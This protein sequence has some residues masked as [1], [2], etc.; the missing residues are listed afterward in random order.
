LQQKHIV[1]KTGGDIPIGGFIILPMIL[2]GKSPI[3]EE[4]AQRDNSTGSDGHRGS[5]SDVYSALH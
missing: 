3:F 2:R 1:E 4:R 5:I